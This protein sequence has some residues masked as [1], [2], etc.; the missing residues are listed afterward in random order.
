MKHVNKSSCIEVCNVHL[1]AD[2]NASLGDLVLARLYDHGSNP[3]TTHLVG[4]VEY[5]APELTRTRT[6]SIGTDVFA[7]GIFPL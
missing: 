5:L 1:D 6:P 3:R 4:T 7:F 2:I